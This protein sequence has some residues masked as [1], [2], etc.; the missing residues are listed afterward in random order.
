VTLAPAPMPCCA[1]ARG[2]PGE[3]AGDAL[4]GT[5]TAAQQAMDVKS[6]D[7]PVEAVQAAL[8]GDDKEQARRDA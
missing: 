7:E 1:G 2:D 6:W 5:E 8:D 3:V 4:A